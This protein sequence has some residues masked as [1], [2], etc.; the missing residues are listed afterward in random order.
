[1]SLGAT[2]ANLSSESGTAL[3]VALRS[4]GHLVE[5][6]ACGELFGS[7]TLETSDVLN[8]YCLAK[9]V[10]S[11][12]V[13]WA[14]EDA[15]FS[16]VL[17]VPVAEVCS[18]QVSAPGLTLGELLSHDAGLG[19][20][21]GIEFIFGS[22]E[23]RAQWR[24]VGCNSSREFSEVSVLL[25]LDDLART[26]LS[27]PLGDL[28]ERHLVAS[29]HQ[30]GI[31]KPSSKV[32][33]CFV[34]HVSRAGRPWLHECLVQ[35]EHFGWVLDLVGIHAS[36][37]ALCAWFDDVA[38][39]LSVGSM[40]FPS[41]GTMRQLGLPQRRRADLRSGR[42]AAFALGFMVGMSSH[43]LDVDEEQDFGHTGLLWTAV[44]VACPRSKSTAVVQT[45]TLELA[46][47]G[48]VA[49]ETVRRAVSAAIDH[50]RE[51]SP[52]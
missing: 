43:G 48:G 28:V 49:G 8:V 50:G 13:L 23:S 32:S 5:S 39:L 34:P 20:P 6:L 52:W 46:H 51:L 45:P 22:A 17:N 36:A 27:A 14:L 37:E 15:G 38:G 42:V 3:Q 21:T 33:E 40:G 10:V 47:D 35:D 30:S 9:P 2:I 29:G 19:S 24:T 7:R 41:V 12:A 26:T 11:V 16:D 1:V 25:V 44:A 18:S 4:D 31:S